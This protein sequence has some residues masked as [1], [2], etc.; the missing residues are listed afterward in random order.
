MEKGIEKGMKLEHAKLLKTARAL[1]SS[2]MSKQQV[3]DI[4]ELSDEEISELVKS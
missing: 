4:T 2:G 1:L 3:K